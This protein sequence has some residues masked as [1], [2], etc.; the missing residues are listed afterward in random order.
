MVSRTS[1]WRRNFCATAMPAFFT[2]AVPPEWRVSWK[3]TCLGMGLAQ[4][5]GLPQLGQASGTLESGRRSFQPQ[6]GGGAV[7]VAL[8]ENG[9]VD[10]GTE[11]PLSRSFL[12][13]HRAVGLGRTRSQ[14]ASFRAFSGADRVVGE[15]TGKPCRP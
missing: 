10:G 14:G 4:T 8:V 3:R 5:E 11:H 7:L 1:E 13:L 12:G 2:I 15:G 6:W 9:T